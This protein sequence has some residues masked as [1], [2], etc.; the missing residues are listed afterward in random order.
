VGYP[1]SAA[2]P[3]RR[4]HNAFCTGRDRIALRATGD[5]EKLLD[6]ARGAIDA[7]ADAEVIDAALQHLVETVENYEAVKR[8]VDAELAEQLPTEVVRLTLYPRVR[9]D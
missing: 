9:T 5:R 2:V 7:D 4:V 1:G 8:E 6:Q 3:G